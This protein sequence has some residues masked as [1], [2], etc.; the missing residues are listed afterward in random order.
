MTAFD[1]EDRIY[2]SLLEITRR[3]KLLALSDNCY[4]T[5]NGITMPAKVVMY[6]QP[7]CESHARQAIREEK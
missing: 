4:L 5:H 6:G 7:V 2:A 3:D 1:E